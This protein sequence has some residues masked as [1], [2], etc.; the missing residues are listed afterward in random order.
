M[1]QT[2]ALILGFLGIVVLLYLYS[3][4]TTY[5]A[6]SRGAYVHIKIGD[7]LIEKPG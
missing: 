3:D 7:R 2:S 6:Y 1:Y 5:A 4:N